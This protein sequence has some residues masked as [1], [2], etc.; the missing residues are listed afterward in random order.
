LTAAIQRF[1]PNLRYPWLF[2]I[3]AGLFLA[4]LVTPDPIPLLDEAL[5]A[6]LTFIAASFRTRTEDRPP[7]R[8]ITPED[9]ED[10]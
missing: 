2:L 1:L 8:D 6:V 10:A 5:L 9:E 7:P 3:L 4:D